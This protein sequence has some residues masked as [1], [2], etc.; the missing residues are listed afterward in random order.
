M[1]LSGRGIE[2]ASRLASIAAG[3]NLAAVYSSTE[4][5]AQA[6]ALIIGDAAGQPVSIVEGLQELR[7]DRWI[8]NS[9]DFSET[10][11]EILD[12]PDISAHGAERAASAAARFAAAVGMIEEGPFPAAIVS[13]GRV[14]TAYLAQLRAL[15]DPFAVW[16]SMPMPGWACLALDPPAP[17]LIEPFSGLSDAP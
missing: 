10:V 11:R 3:W 17:K 13:H 2:E 14:L 5:K 4:P 15:D 16:R 6:T 7:F 12:Q 9:D 8:I 1:E